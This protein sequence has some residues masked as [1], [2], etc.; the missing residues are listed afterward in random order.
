[1]IVE[2]AMVEEVTDDSTDAGPVEK[3]TGDV[4]VENIPLTEDTEAEVI[5]DAIFD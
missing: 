1:M 2:Y 4:P 5:V 3:L